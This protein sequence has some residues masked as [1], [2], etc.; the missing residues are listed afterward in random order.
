MA[1]KQFEE[2]WDIE[3]RHELFSL[4]PLSSEEDAPQSTIPL[5]LT[6]FFMGEIIKLD[7]YQRNFVFLLKLHKT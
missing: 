2:L 6:I 3:T 7:P 5:P 1:I 4:L